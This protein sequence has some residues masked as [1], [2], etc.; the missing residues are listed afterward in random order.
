MLALHSGT[1]FN[2]SLVFEAAGMAALKGKIV[3]SGPPPA[4]A[5]DALPQ[6]FARGCLRA[7]SF[8]PFCG[9]VTSELLSSLKLTEPYGVGHSPPSAKHTRVKYYVDNV[10]RWGGDMALL[11]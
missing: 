3:G 2:R 9:G 6:G 4:F 8:F 10:L 7:H 1:G 5:W 11:L